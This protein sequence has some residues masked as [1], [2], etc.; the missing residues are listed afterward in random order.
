MVTDDKQIDDGRH[1][2]KHLVSQEYLFLKLKVK[3]IQQF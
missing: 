3:I 2:D 1:T